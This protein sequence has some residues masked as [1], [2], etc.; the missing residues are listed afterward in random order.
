MTEERALAAL[1]ADGITFTNNP[2]I[3]SC[4]N[5]SNVRVHDVVCILLDLTVNNILAN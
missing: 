3:S 5:F 4:S 1:L 2:L